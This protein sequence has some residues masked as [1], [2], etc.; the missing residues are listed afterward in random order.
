MQENISARRSYYRRQNEKRRLV[1]TIVAVPLIAIAGFLFWHFE[2]G[3]EHTATF[4]VKSLDDQSGGSSHTYLI[5]T[6][7]DHVYR[8]TDSWLHGKTDSSNVWG[9]LQAG[10]T[11]S[12]PV[13]GYRIFF[14]SSYPDILDGC[15][16]VTPGVPASRRHV[17]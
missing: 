15:T 9:W 4:T 6:S 7:D 16:D 2:Y 5:F 1:K 13:Y 14:F 8:D 10:H 17:P 12:C 11:Y 3:T